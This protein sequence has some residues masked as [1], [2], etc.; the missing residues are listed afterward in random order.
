MQLGCCEQQAKDTGTYSEKGKDVFVTFV[1]LEKA[2]DR[3]SWMKLIEILK[4]I[5]M[6]CKESKLI[7]NLFVHRCG[8]GGCMHTCHAAGP[9]SFTGRDKFPG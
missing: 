3:V 7:S 5:G 1:D 4:K 9:G 6:D 2:F 8:P